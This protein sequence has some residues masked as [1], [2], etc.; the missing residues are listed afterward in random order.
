MPLLPWSVMCS[1]WSWYCTSQSSS[2]HST[3]FS[4]PGVLCQ[5][6]PICND[7]TPPGVGF[8]LHCLALVSQFIESCP[9][10]T[11][12]PDEFIHTLWHTHQGHDLLGARQPGG[13]DPVPTVNDPQQ[14]C[15]SRSG[16]DR[17]H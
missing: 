11:Q 9:D 6:E 16:D 14:V 2:C 15:L 7:G 17:R 10:F 3:M 12:G 5:R 13:R 1:I 4:W 8:R